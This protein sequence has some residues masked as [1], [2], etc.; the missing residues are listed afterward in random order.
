MSP[1]GPII[2]FEIKVFRK[3]LEGANVSNGQDV[4]TYKQ[5]RL[6]QILLE[7]SRMIISFGSA[8]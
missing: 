6:R 4:D 2:P 3:T 5:N 7:K 1:G 8:Q